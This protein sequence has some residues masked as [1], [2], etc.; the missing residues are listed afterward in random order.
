MN[1]LILTL[2]VLVSLVGCTKPAEESIKRGEFDVQKL[3]TYEGC[4][5]YRFR[6]DRNIYYTNCNGST[7]HLE[8]CGKNCSY[9]EIVPT[10]QVP[11]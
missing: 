2:A 11:Y 3:F 10:S 5:V 8:S 7:Q 6:D 9:Q 1:K 4:T